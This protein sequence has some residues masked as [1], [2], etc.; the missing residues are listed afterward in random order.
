MSA[1]RR[2]TQTAANPAARGPILCLILAFAALL[3]GAGREDLVGLPAPGPQMGT[4]P[5]VLS[6]PLEVHRKLT[7]ELTGPVSNELANPSPFRDFAFDVRFVHTASGMARLVPG[8]F[9]ADG[10]ASETGA[11]AG[12][13]WKAHLTPGVAGSWTWQ[14]SFRVGS[15]VA[16]SPLGFG[17][18]L[19]PFNGMTG[20]FDVAVGD[21]NS[22]NP[23]RDGGRLL[24]DS[25]HHLRHEVSRDPWLQTGVNSP[26]NFLAYAEFDQTPDGTHGYAPHLADWQHG[27]PAW[28]GDADGK[29]IVGALNYLAEVGVNTISMLTFNV[30]GDGHDVWP[31]TS[32][33]ERLRYDVSKLDQWE[34][35]FEHMDEMGISPHLI[36]QE[37]END[38]G[39][40]ALDGGELGLERMLYHRELL[41]RFGHHLGLVIN[42]GEENQNSFDQQVA[43]YDHIRSL[44]AYDHPIVLHTFP[45]SMQTVYQPLLAAG[46][47]EGASLQVLD[48][49]DVHQTTLDVLQWSDDAERPWVVNL[50][51]IGPP[52]DGVLPDADDFWHHGPRIEALWGNLMAGGGGV[53]WYFGYAWDH[54]D[55]TLEDFRSRDHLFALSTWA[56]QFLEP[57]PF[58]LMESVDALVTQGTAWVLRRKGE[59]YAAYLPSGG[60]VT[61]T[62]PEPHST[63]RV[64][65]TDPRT[66]GSTSA[67]GTAFHIPGEPLVLDAPSSG[68]DEDWAVAVERLG[69]APGITSLSAAPNPFPGGDLTISAMVPDQDGDVVSAHA[70]IFDPHGQWI[71]VLPLDPQGGD[72]WQITLPGQA[73]I[74]PGT[75]TV[76][77]VAEDS[78]GQVAWSTTPLEAI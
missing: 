55:L 42:L 40:D 63:W 47:L 64:R 1:P 67:G 8:Y 5:V 49:A 21:L 34:L 45:T 23:L 18:P 14:V 43:F 72:L 33:F 10:D 62:F 50:D 56:R 25:G 76:M 51:E 60:S 38:T 7:L 37:Q 17:A 41:A 13:K 26:E 78:L 36:L 6:G 71:G 61:L 69:L 57:L 22:G 44:D 65:W 28:H 20:S 30:A 53:Q 70:H 77:L 39:P 19:M 31:F 54:N 4:G 9:A 2:P 27:N 29:G 52:D 11:T 59:T 35:V 32:K 48:M 73:P 46:K 15:N 12:R 66:V 16:L 68:P 75:W 58:D 74:T 3:T 24:L